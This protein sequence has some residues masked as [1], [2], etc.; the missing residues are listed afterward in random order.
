MCVSE[1]IPFAKSFSNCLSQSFSVKLNAFGFVLPSASFIYN[2]PMAE[3]KTKNKFSL[4][5]RLAIALPVVLVAVIAALGIFF[6][7]RLKKH[8]KI[9]TNAFANDGADEVIEPEI[10]PPPAEERRVNRI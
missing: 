4:K 2:Q 3:R 8:R 7:V 1:A 6:V 5:K 10:A 9:N